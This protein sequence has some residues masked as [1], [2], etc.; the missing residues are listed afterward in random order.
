MF[1]FKFDNGSM[2]MTETVYELLEVNVYVFMVYGTLYVCI[3][4]VRMG[5]CVGAQMCCI[6]GPTHNSSK[7]LTSDL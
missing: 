5:D 7:V 3:C 1:I 4:N 6:K 2:I